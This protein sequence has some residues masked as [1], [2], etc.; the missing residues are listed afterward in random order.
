[1]DNGASSYRRF[2]EGDWDG[3]TEIVSEY[4]KGLVLYLNTYL[5][6]LQDAEDMA[7]ETLLV[8][9][10][11][12]PV[13]KGNASFKTWIYG[14]GRNVTCISLRKNHRVVPVS[15]DDLSLLASQEQDAAEEFFLDEEKRVLHRCLL[16][17]RTEFRQ[18]LWLR[19]F[20]DM[21][22][23]EIAKVMSKTKYSVNQ[24][25][26]RAKKALREEMAKEG[27]HARY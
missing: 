18:V 17:L 23:S 6:N 22:A 20:E 5:N 3:L 12:K 13:Y 4:Y 11:Q 21:S 16:R 25:T 2:L 27:Y 7:E 9:T 19:Y 10:T 1:M 26:A 15:P 8:L 14:I 24:L